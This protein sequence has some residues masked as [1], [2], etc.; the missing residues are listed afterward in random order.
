MT[1]AT[2][3]AMRSLA[4][5][6][7]LVLALE[8]HAAPAA[9]PSA[10]V[11]ASCSRASPSMQSAVLEAV[12]YG[13]GPLAVDVVGWMCG[14]ARAGSFVR[15]VMLRY[16]ARD[17]DGR[18]SGGGELVPVVFEDGRMLAHGWFLFE[19][20]PDRYGVLL[21]TRADPFRAPDGW[22]VVKSERELA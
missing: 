20:Q 8:S 4:T 9:S 10:E 6:L 5:V 22:V 2:D 18:P 17:A 13:G 11:A 16:P 19:D 21:P 12:V 3:S 1:L 7:G 15:V 14:R